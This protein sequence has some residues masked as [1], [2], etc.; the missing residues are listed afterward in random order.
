MYASLSLTDIANHHGVTRSRAL[1]YVQ[2]G[3]YVVEP[4][5]LEINVVAAGVKPSA[6]TIKK[7]VYVQ[8]REIKRRPK[9][10]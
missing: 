1:Q 3:I 8:T 4:H 2:S 6:F 9:T 10:S 7:N 5:T